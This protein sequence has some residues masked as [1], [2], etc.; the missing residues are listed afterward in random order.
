MFAMN[1]PGANY[2]LEGSDTEWYDGR[3]IFENQV[4]VYQDGKAWVVG[5]MRERGQLFEIGRY[6]EKETAIKCA[7]SYVDLL[8]SMG[9]M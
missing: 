6:V 3:S 4:G 5:H 8:K 7:S 9:V 2:M 1:S